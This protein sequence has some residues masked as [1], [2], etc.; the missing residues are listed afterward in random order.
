LFNNLKEI[1]HGEEKGE[2]RRQEEKEEES[3][4]FDQIKSK[5]AHNNGSSHYLAWDTIAR[6]GL[7]KFYP[8]VS[9]LGLEILVLK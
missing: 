7:T 8:W 9:T 2:K 5:I 4:P 6:E 3:I 1:E